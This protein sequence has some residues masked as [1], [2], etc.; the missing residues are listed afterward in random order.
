MN[1]LTG[2]DSS[3]RTGSLI[4]MIPGAPVMVAERALRVFSLNPFRLLFATVTI[5]ELSS[6]TPEPTRMVEPMVSPFQAKTHKLS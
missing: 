4:P 1:K 2:L 3:E 5:S 6:G